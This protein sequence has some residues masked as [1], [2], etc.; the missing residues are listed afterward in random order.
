MGALFPYPW[1]FEA[2]VMLLVMILLAICLR[3]W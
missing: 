1:M 3:Y 2:G